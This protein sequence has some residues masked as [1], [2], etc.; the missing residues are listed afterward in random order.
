[1]SQPVESRAEHMHADLRRVFAD[2][3]AF[4]VMVGAGE[5]YL[6]AFVLAL[7]MGEV[8]AGLIAAVP[9]LA[10]GAIQLVSPWAVRVL[11]SHRR[12]V[13]ACATVQACAFIPL[14]TAGLM[15]RMP[16]WA[17]YLAASVYWGAG[18]ATGPAWNTWVSTLVPRAIRAN[19][20][21]HRSR[22]AH[23][24]VLVGL[25]GAGL[26]LQMGESLGQ[27]LTAFA[28]IFS[29]AGVARFISAALL[30]RQSEPHKPDDEH[31]LVSWPQFIARFRHGADGRLLLYMLAMQFAVQISGPYFTPFMLEKLHFSYATYLLLIAT[32]YVSRMA[33]LPWLGEWV[34]RA[35]ARRVLW[36]AGTG[37]VPLSALWLV[38]GEIWWLIIVQVLAGA[39]WAAYELATFLLLF[40]TIPEEERT[41]VLTLFNAM[42]AL[43]T[44]C[45]AAC[46]GWLLHAMDTT[47][48]AYLTV[49]ALSGCVRLALIVLLARAARALPA[50]D[51]PQPA[52]PLPTR[53]LAV[54]PNVGSFEKPILP[55]L[56]RE[57]LLDDGANGTR[58][59]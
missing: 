44:V 46:S 30:F 50:R 55:A 6:A 13:V 56:S 41:S 26:S 33:V 12:W 58:D 53:V 37:I 40:E 32:S 21:A 39:A 4:S 20:F 57:A 29:A 45:G 1:M 31:R 23:M 19:Y 42:H 35:G 18:L 47:A 27:P 59:G 8:N 14:V 25:V 7:G 24:A 16:V 5:T 43:A 9:M 34:R 51:I 28:I 48:A 2:A 36:F 3:I 17:M 52:L 11:R 22:M 49:F 38:S 10:G 15:G 54:R